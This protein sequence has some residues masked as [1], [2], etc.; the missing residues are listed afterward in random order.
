MYEINVELVIQ[1]E[2]KMPLPRGAVC[3]RQLVNKTITATIKW[4]QFQTECHPKR[5]TTIVI[6]QGSQ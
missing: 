1:A 4:S 5:T 6:L 3:S 2:S